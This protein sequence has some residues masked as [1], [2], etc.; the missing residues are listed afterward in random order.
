MPLIAGAM[1]YGA[2]TQQDDDNER[3]MR[4]Q[5]LT[6]QQGNQA[7]L[8]EQ[9]RA[10]AMLKMQ[11]L[12][13]AGAL[14]RE[15]DFGS[16]TARDFGLAGMD[17]QRQ[18]GVEN[19]RGQNQLGVANVQMAPSLMGAQLDTKKYLDSRDDES[20]RRDLGKRAGTEF[21]SMLFDS[22]GQ[23]QGG[24][25]GA[26]NLPPSP[27]ASPPQPKGMY[28]NMMGQDNS[29]IAIAA[30]QAL[31]QRLGSQTPQSADRLSNLE[32]MQ[33]LASVASG[34][35]AIPDIAGSRAAA[36]ANELAMLKAKREDDAIRMKAA[37]DAGDFAQA[38][39]IGAS[40][41]LPVPDQTFAAQAL[42]TDPVLNTGLQE[43]KLMA[44]KL[45]PSAFNPVGI[46]RMATTGDA[47]AKSFMEKIQQLSEYAKAKGINP[48]QF[49][50]ALRSSVG[51]SADS[52]LLD[53]TG[54]NPAKMAL[55]I[56]Q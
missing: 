51:E 8:A 32:R 37:I 6:S 3:F 25:P 53:M 55:G 31:K 19:I 40:S 2:P 33:L 30:Q 42:A 16:K 12:Q 50:A 21:S 56:P 43:I 24:P 14:Q 23:N 35:G 9:I 10:A 17:T 1:S 5:A 7:A 26:P 52:L 38:R 34:K 49:K 29:P 11:E 54:S 28:D 48:E 13:N 45:S 46:L 22:T 36:A 44:R 15:G 27:G 20:W 39:Q 41:G 18:F 4:Q 47:M